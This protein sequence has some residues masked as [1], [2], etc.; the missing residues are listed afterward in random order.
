M[1]LSFIVSI[2]LALVAALPVLSEERISDVASSG[3][4]K[5]VG[6]YDAVTDEVDEI[7]FDEVEAADAADASDA[8]SES[9]QG[10][11]KRDRKHSKD[12]RRRSSRRRS[13][14]HSCRRKCERQTK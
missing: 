6:L 11:K 1:K 5:L 13:I 3:P 14:S 4:K 2:A 12:R 10:H 8:A 7:K 9:L